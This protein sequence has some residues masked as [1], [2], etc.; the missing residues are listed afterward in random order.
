[1]GWA[2][3]AETRLAPIKPTTTHRTAGIFIESF[4]KKSYHEHVM[5]PS[6]K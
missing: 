5:R 2:A 4:S 3:A 6:A 1:M